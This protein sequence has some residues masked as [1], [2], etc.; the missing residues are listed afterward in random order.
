[1]SDGR[2]KE[3]ILKKKMMRAFLGITIKEVTTY[4]K[5]RDSRYLSEV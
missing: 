3:Y 4:D 1:M 5:Q 2:S